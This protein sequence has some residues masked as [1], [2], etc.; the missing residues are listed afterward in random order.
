M[1]K[2]TKYKFSDLYYMA[3]GISSTKEQAG[4]G[5]P[6]LS[7]SVVFNN[8]FIPD[9]LS[10]LMDASEKEKEIYSIKS[11]DIFLTR[12]SEVVDE[13][14][15]S[16]VAVKDYPEATFSGFLKR[17][18]PTQR[19]ITY[20]KFMAFYL[21]SPMFRKTMTNN[22]VM[23]LRASLNEAIFSYL[24]LLLP[25]YSEQR[26]AGDLLYLLNQKI[27]LNN[28]INSELESTAK[29]L[30]DYWFVQFDF[31]DANGKPYKTSGGK[32]VY[33]ATLKRE[34]PVGWSSGTLDDLGQISGGSTPSTSNSE[35]FTEKGMP[36]I[37]PN[38]LSNNQGNKFIS[39]G[40]L[41]VSEDGIKN[42]S[43][44]AY[45]AGTVL[46]SSRAPIGYMAIAR[47][48]L[49]TNQGFKSFIPSKGYSA[50]FIFY[51]VK[52]SLPVIVKNASGST[53]KE[54][55][56]AVL[57]K[58]EITLPETSIVNQ[59]TKRVMSIFSRQNKL[60]LENQQLVT[61]RD[62]LLPLLMNGQ[63]TVK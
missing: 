34:I 23:T 49:T 57:K 14:A 22:A 24:D 38:D 20:P 10:D 9:A 32:M 36:W 61:L 51:A 44:K 29:T 60:E 52:N 41:D 2:L 7:F 62:W 26:K 8:Y 28:R 5:S 18:R 16:C 59:Y 17:L 25:S 39:R 40:A 19:H 58:I 37:T 54:V 43:L 6:F 30:Y 13:L 11:G 56:G 50:E 47:N 48:E 53:F 42:A 12:T 27:D 33:N 35:N 31:P 21:R 55:S 63:V 45:P 4:H 46:L 3:S 15:M 1:S